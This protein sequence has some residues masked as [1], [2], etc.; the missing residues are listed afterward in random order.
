MNPALRGFRERM[1]ASLGRA[2]PKPIAEHFEMGLA[3][4]LRAAAWTP[5]T[6]SAEERRLRDRL[7]RPAAP[8]LAL[9]AEADCFWMIRPF[10]EPASRYWEVSL[11]GLRVRYPVPHDRADDDTGADD[12][13]LRADGAY[14]RLPPLLT[15]FSDREPNGPAE[16]LLRAGVYAL[17]GDKVDFGVVDDEA[18]MFKTVV[19]TVTAPA[20]QVGL[21]EAR[22]LDPD[23]AVGETLGWALPSFGGL[24]GLFDWLRSRQRP[25]P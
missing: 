5:F 18:Y 17:A 6:P 9:W 2:D 13:A 22:A 10:A 15:I 24:Y 23:C 8:P 3:D 4:A 21:A 20:T 16:R 1:A 11:D 14:T 7:A 19:E 12:V 25:R